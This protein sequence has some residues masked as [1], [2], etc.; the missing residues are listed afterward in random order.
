MRISHYKLAV[1]FDFML[2]IRTDSTDSQWVF[3][4]F[5]LRKYYTL[6]DHQR[7]QVAFALAAT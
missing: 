3:G 2:C 7:K 5:F 6:Y 4:V 1:Q